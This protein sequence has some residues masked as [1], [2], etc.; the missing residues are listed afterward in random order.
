MSEKSIFTQELKVSKKNTTKEKNIRNTTLKSTLY[1]KKTKKD[2]GR[3]PPRVFTGHEEITF[4]EME[5]KDKNDEKKISKSR[6]R[7]E[8][9]KE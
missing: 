8:R 2:K 7:A 4:F 3:C 9:E 1:V 5:V 6:K